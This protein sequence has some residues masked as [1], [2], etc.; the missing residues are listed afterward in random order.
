MTVI[1]ERPAVRALQPSLI[2]KLANTAI[3]R[4]DVI[5]LWFGEPDKPTPAFIRQ[6][7]KDAIDEGQT[8]YQPSLGLSE[9]RAALADYTNGLYGAAITPDNIVVTPSGMTALTVALQCIVADGAAVVAPSP[10]W[11]NVAGA[12]EILGAE[13]VR[14]PIRP[15]AG[16]W[17]LDLDELFDACP[18]HTGALAV[19][20]PSNPTGWML[21]DEEQ[22]RIIDFCRERDIWLIA[23]EVYNRI[24]Y[25]REVAP[26]FAD[27]VTDDDKFLLINSFSKS[28][29]MTGWR[30]GWL[31]A[32]SSLVGT[33]GMVGEFNFSCVFAPTQFAGV[34]ALR[35]GEAFI[36][37]SRERYRA[38]RDLVAAR[39]AD[40]PRVTFPTPKAA[41]YAFFAVDGVTDSYNFALEV[42]RDCGVGLTP[43]A[44]FG[45]QGEGYLRLC[46][47]AEPALLERALTQ[48]RP[49]LT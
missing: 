37:A 21:E 6:A 16:V 22:Q 42:L 35:E 20:S 24:V 39:L 12:A 23:D 27:K 49:L 14:V 19:N 32:P 30:L 43:G 5:P 38:A 15:R 9:L 17:T 11:P 3:G 10:D 13:I 26:S 7:A 33:L 25:D 8:F 46:F 34:T 48:M 40:L 47:A 4:S 44:A 1:A 45:P 28:W 31:T 36:S 41:F 29:A 18:A 2:R